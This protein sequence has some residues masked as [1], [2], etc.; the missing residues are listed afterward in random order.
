M[1]N[2]E[3][4]KITKIID[5]LKRYYGIKT[6][7]KQNPFRVL[8]STV[9]SQRTRDEN[10][11]KATSLLFSKYKTIN[12][13]ANASEKELRKLIKS[14]GFY[15]QKA[16]SIKEISRILVEKYKGKVPKNFNELISLPRVG[17]KTANCVLV[18]GFG[19]PAIPVDTHVHRISNRIGLVKT[20]KP[21]ETEKE[22]RKNVPK[23]YWVVLNH[24]L[25]IHGQTLCLAIRPKCERCPIKSVCKTGR[26]KL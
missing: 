4:R 13:I 6:P 25:V 10:T 24:L 17:R 21:E 20:K 22:L 1:T 12:D 18:Y 11:K 15:R 23:K 19:I 16:K 8:I 26:H 2:K 9:L 7:A 5:L 14:V 3:I